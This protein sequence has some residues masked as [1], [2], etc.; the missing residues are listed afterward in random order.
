MK[1]ILSKD[2]ISIL[3]LAKLMEIKFKLNYEYVRR[4]VEELVSLK[5]IKRVKHNNETLLLW[6]KEV[7]TFDYEQSS[8]LVRLDK[9]YTEFITRPSKVRQ[10]MLPLYIIA[11]MAKG[12]ANLSEKFELMLEIKAVKSDGVW[13][14]IERSKEIG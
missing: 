6:T 11:E 8:N 9:Q 1:E 13:Y 3:S 7:I 2:P 4:E 5:K 12:I 14:K 10:M